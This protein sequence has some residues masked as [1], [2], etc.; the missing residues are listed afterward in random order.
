MILVTGASGFVGHH[1]ITALTK[2][3]SRNSIRVFDAKP[4]SAVLPE[5]VQALYGLL[6]EPEQVAAVVHGAE[7]VIHLAAKVQPYSRESREMWRVNV[8]GTRNVYSA[9]VDS[10]CKLFL[11]MSSAGIYGASP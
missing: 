8:E 4:S 1:L 9:A 2:R 10:G 5:G 11:H 3:F 6:E 7:V